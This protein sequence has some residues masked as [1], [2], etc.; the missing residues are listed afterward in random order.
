MQDVDELSLNR[1]QQF[2]YRCDK[3]QG[4]LR[5]VTDR[6]VPEETSPLACVGVALLAALAATA[7]CCVGRGGAA[8]ATL[9][10]AVLPAGVLSA[11]I[12]LLMVHVAAAAFADSVAQRTTGS[13]ATAVFVLARHSLRAVT[14]G[15]LLTAL[16]YGCA[17]PP[18]VAPVVVLAAQAALYAVHWV[19]H[20]TGRF[21]AARLLSPTGLVVL[22]ALA[23]VV[24]HSQT[25]AAPAAAAAAHATLAQV[26]LGA[27]AGGAALVVAVQALCVAYGRARPRPCTAP[28]QY[29]VPAALHVAL[30]LL[31]YA[32]D[33]RAF[34]A[35]PFF[36]LQTYTW[37]FAAALLR[38]VVADMLALAPPRCG[39]PQAALA[40]CCVA[41]RLCPGDARLVAAAAAAALSFA[42]FAYSFYVTVAAVHDYLMRNPNTPLALPFD[43]ESNSSNN[44][45]EQPQPQQQ[46]QQEQPQPAAC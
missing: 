4:V 26:V 33:P 40:A 39:W 24:A 29:L 42:A 41:T 12:V 46:P 8:G 10:G 14:L 15:L 30:G 43:D 45:S 22:L 1:L 35:A 32:L 28:A 5:D 3:E 21:R 34:A 11:V 6:V 18:G 13:G 36:Y 44:S 25:S 38:L 27:V 20:L 9:D 19:H 2:S 37:L 17:L 7:L 16:C 23:L 31:W